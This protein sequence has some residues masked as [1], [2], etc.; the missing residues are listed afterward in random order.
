MRLREHP[1]MS[2]RGRPNWPTRKDLGIC[3]Y[4]KKPQGEA[5]VLENVRL[6]AVNENALFLS[7]SYGG[8]RYIAEL[9]FDD[10]NVLSKAL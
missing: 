7:M 10:S 4:D 9:I 5:G 6:S 2:C 8:G 3:T 1:L